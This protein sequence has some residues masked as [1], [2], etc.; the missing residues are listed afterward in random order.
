MLHSWNNFYFFFFL[1]FLSLSAQWGVGNFFFPVFCCCFAK[2]MCFK[3]IK[4]INFELSRKNVVP[5]RSF[6]CSL[7]YILYNTC[8]HHLSGWIKMQWETIV[9]LFFAID[10]DVEFIFFCLSSF[11]SEN[12]ENEESSMNNGKNTTVDVVLF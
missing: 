10:D 8:N 12:T 4:I 2:F 3:R 9:R 1:F 11:A 5:G 7:Y 6:L